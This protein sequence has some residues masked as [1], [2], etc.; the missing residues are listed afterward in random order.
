MMDKYKKNQL[1]EV[2]NISLKGVDLSLRVIDQPKEFFADPDNSR[3]LDNIA[4]TIRE[5]FVKPDM[6]QKGIIS[7]VVSPEHLVILE[8]DGKVYGI[9]SYNKTTL[10]GTPVLIV[11]GVAIHPSFQGGGIFR[12][13]T[14]AVNIKRA[15]MGLK[16]QNPCMYGAFENY[17]ET[18]YPGACEAP[19]VIES[20]RDSMA[21]YMGY[22]SEGSWIIKGGYGSQLY[23]EEPSHSR[24]S[25]F[26]RENLGMDYSAGDVLLVVGVM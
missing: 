24:H 9:G 18:I 11:K 16:T 8:G 6:A 25:R 10:S 2:K 15:V 13:M 5:A 19:K 4:S 21:K 3:L 1:C 23:G 22:N 26:F 14:D 20:I 7:H 17:C 12:A